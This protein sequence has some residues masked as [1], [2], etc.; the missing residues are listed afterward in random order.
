MF[1]CLYVQYGI[2]ILSLSIN[3]AKKNIVRDLVSKCL[4]RFRRLAMIQF[5]HIRR[6]ASVSVH[7]LQ[8]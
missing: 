2:E 1:V 8:H 7:S 3:N 6:L 5:P 4:I